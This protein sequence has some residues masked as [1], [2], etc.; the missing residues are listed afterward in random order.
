MQSKGAG[1]GLST[2]VDFRAKKSSRDEGHFMAE[3]SSSI[4]NTD[5][6]TNSFNTHRANSLS[7]AQRHRKP[8][9]S[10]RD[11]TPPLT[12]QLTE[13]EDVDGAQP[14]APADLRQQQNSL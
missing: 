7:T 11:P 1:V 8:A 2:R 9:S 5:V 3:G 12:Q 14:T 4:L 10:G 6:P 13:P